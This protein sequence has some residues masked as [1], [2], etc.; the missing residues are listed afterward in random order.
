MALY[1]GFPSI[2]LEGDEDR[3]L[4]LI[5]EAKALLY[6]LQVF[7]QRGGVDTYSMSRSAG[8]DGYIYVRAAQGLYNITISVRPK[9]TDQKYAEPEIP[10]QPTLPT[11]LSGMVLRGYEREVPRLNDTPVMALA[12]FAPTP[13]CQQTSNLDAGQ[14]LSA[15]LAVLP[16][17]PELRNSEPLPIYTQYTMLR[18]S[19][20]SG[21]MQAV[22]QVLMGL[23]RLSRG[24]LR[25]M[26]LDPSAPEAYIG[27]IR[28]N[29]VQI[30]YDYKFHRTHGIVV[31]ADDRLWL[32][33]ISMARGVLAMPLPMFVDSTTASFKAKYLGRDDDSMVAVVEEFGGLPTGESFPE[34]TAA[35]D[36]RIKRG[37]ILRLL[38]ASDLATF[39]NASPYSSALGWAFS[40]DGSEAHNTAYYYHEDGY[41][42]GIWWQLNLRIGATLEDWIPGEGPL[43]VATCSVRPMG[44]GYLYSDHDVPATNP[45]AYLPFK[46]HEPGFGLFSHSARSIGNQPPVKCDTVVHAC[47]INGDFHAV[48]FYRNPKTDDYTEIDDPRF[49]GECLYAGSWTVTE[50][51]GT[52][53]F[54]PS[55]YSNRQ[56]DRRVLREYV[57]T[58]QIDS[59]DLG[60][61]P[62]QY[63]DLTIYLQYSHV[64]RTRYFKNVISTTV[65]QGEQMVC[66]VAVPEFAREAYYMATGD[67]VSSESNTTTTNYTGL[68]DPNQGY[69]WRCLA[70]FGDSPAPFLPDVDPKLCGGDCSPFGGSRN[71]HSERRVIFTFHTGSA[72]CK[73]YADSGPWLE[74]CQSIEGT[75]PQPSY[76]PA[77]IVTTPAEPKSSGRLRLF[78]T[79]INGDKTSELSYDAVYRWSLPSPHPVTGEVHKI[80]AYH[81]AFGA[82]AIC[83]MTD[84]LTYGVRVTEG[85]FL[86]PVTPNDPIPCFIGVYKP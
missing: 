30:R 27:D 81:N 82:E 20:Y 8:D 76:P 7:L 72:G 1:D 77:A 34:N 32:V 2:R 24:M 64:F 10:V 11:I 39:Y 84:Y 23:G 22:V 21:K 62:L 18:P 31:A 47:F 9:V 17:L 5:P 79:G 6:K 59:I 28:A 69:A 25:T 56:D 48:K 14:Q 58:E 13:D 73:D 86:T 52:R 35:L 67:Y 49:E 38:A 78:M 83:Y 85:Y 68:S 36:A 37:D 71:V 46:T 80:S 12:T 40:P 54:T 61:G 29:G 57:R 26:E 33:E 3:A 50:R 44:E 41:Q 15:R 42:R 51:R 43:A 19:M 55:M 63:S 74:L 45:R 75:G 66:A 16:R 65:R 60:Y 53:G 4:A 70:G